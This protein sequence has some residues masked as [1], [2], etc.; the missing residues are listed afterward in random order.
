[1]RALIEY[2]FVASLALSGIVCVA[3]LNPWP[4]PYEN[5]ILGLIEASRPTLYASHAQRFRPRRTAAGRA[6]SRCR[7]EATLH[8][9]RPRCDGP[10]RLASAGGR[11]RL[12]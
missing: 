3:G 12:S 5:A 7:F 6:L 9:R 11:P 10:P 1:M 4:F 8:R 2:R